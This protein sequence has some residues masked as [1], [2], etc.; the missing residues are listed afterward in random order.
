MSLKQL[1]THVNEYDISLGQ[2]QNGDMINNGLRQGMKVLEKIV[3]ARTRCKLDGTTDACFSDQHF[4]VLLERV[5]MKYSIPSINI[6]PSVELGLI[7]LQTGY[8]QHTL[9]NSMESIHH[10][11]TTTNTEQEFRLDELIEVS[12]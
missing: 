2:T 5:K 3:H 4:L 11:T 10:I 6:S 12:A 7:V 9:N 1:E 8:L